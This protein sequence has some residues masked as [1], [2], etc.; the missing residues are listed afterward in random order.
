MNFK[1]LL[2]ATF[3]LPAMAQEPVLLRSGAFAPPGSLFAT[4]WQK[5]KDNIERESKGTIKVELNT[6]DPNE[7]NLLSNVRRGRVD[8]VGVSLQGSST[9]LPEVGVHFR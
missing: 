5:F 8:C 3:A 7:A 1:L 4:Y 2:L 9:I 6:N